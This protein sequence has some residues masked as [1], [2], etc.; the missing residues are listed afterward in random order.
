MM[1]DSYLRSWCV[2]AIDTARDGAVR[3]GSAG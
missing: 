1:S 3:S 2:I